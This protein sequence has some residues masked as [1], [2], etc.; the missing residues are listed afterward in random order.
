MM[1]GIGVNTV[2]E[3]RSRFVMREVMGCCKDLAAIQM[4]ETLSLYTESLRVESEL[5]NKQKGCDIGEL[6]GPPQWAH[7]AVGGCE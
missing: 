2:R 3:M 5:F 6:K 4:R 1:E 7:R